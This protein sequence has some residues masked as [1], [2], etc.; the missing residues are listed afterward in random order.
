MLGRNVRSEIIPMKTYGLFNPCVPTTRQIDLVTSLWNDIN[1][2]ANKRLMN[3]NEFVA[4]A[5]KYALA[6]LPER[7][8]DE[9]ESAPSKS[10]L[11]GL[12]DVVNKAKEDNDF[13]AQQDCVVID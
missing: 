3:N 12:D 4:Q 8:N 1:D 2:E 6:H 13:W 10:V 11:D 7:F 9:G 5:L